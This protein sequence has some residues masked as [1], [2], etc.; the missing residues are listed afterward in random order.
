MLTAD[1]VRTRRKGRELRL[2]PLE[3]AERERALDLARALLDTVRSH[4]GRTRDDLKGALGALPVGQRDRKLFDGLAKLLED[5]SDWSSDVPLD[6]SA[7]RSAVF[8]EASLRRRSG[9]SFD[10]DATLQHVGRNLGLSDGDAEKY[11]YADLRSAQVLRSVD[12]MD[13]AALVERWEGAQAQAV[14][15]KAVK[16]TVDVRCAAPAAY[17]ELFR[18]L[19]FR[20]LLHEITPLDD[21]YRIVIDGPFSMFESVTKYGLQL[22]L[23]LPALRACDAFTLEADVRWGKQRTPLIFRHEHACAQRD[24]E[25]VLPDDVA[26]VLEALRA[27]DGPWRVSVANTLLNLEGL[28]VCIPD[29]VFEAPGKQRVYLEVMGYWS[30]DAVWRR[31]E[32]AEGGLGERVLFAVSQ[33]LRVSEAVLDDVESAGLYTYKGTMSARAILDR[34]QKLAR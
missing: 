14:L 30:R 17:R 6:P 3:P 26:S 12:S 22:A 29:L 28:G 5:A 16:V 1:L 15:L 27:L 19:K 31:V 13:A 20:Q 24:A 2:A 23:V 11:L 34:V 33:R 4:V 9:E 21:G 18:K 32:L 8:L 7:L 10:R 25:C